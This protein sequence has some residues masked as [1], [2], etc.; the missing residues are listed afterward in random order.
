[1]RWR[2]PSG[3]GRLPGAV[4]LDTGR[5]RAP[6]RRTFRNYVS[7]RAPSPPGPKVNLSEHST[8][9]RV[10]RQTVPPWELGGI[11]EGPRWAA[12]G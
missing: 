10:T 11:L 4:A 2:D 8:V 7:R 5:P 9:P 3:V 6:Y 12:A 1:M